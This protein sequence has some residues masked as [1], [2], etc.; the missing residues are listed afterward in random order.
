[1][2]PFELRRHNR[3]PDSARVM[4]DNEATK[5]RYTLNTKSQAVNLTVEGILCTK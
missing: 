2:L 4:L 5:L 1:M 3:R